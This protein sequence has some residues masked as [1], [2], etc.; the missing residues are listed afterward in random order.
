MSQNIITICLICCLSSVCW[1]NS[2]DPSRQDW[3]RCP[4]LWHPWSCLQPCK[5][6]CTS[7]LP[8]HFFYWWFQTLW[9]SIIFLEASWRAWLVCRGTYSTAP[10]SSSDAHMLIVYALSM[11]DRGHHRLSHWSTQ[12][13]T[14]QSEMRCVV[15]H[16]SHNH[17]YNFTFCWL[18]PDGI[19]FVVLMHTD[20][21]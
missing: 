20:N 16:S 7:P 10:R 4:G 2:T 3:W 5:Q 8:A 15:T 19:A 9:F 11:A 1:Q 12:P 13:H 14:Q 17:H 18:R 21:Y 6:A